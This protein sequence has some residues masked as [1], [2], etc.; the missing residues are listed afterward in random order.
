MGISKKT[1]YLYVESKSDLIDKLLESTPEEHHNVCITD[2]TGE[3]NAID[4]LLSVSKKVCEEISQFNPSITFDLQKYY[5]EIF[6]KFI[7]RK[8]QEIYEKIKCNIEKGIEEDIYRKDLDVDLVARLYVQRLEIFNN[9]DFFLSV[10]KS[11]QKVFGVMFENHIRGIS[12][13][14]G[15]AYLEKQKQL[16]NDNI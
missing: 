3:G 16:L 4:I 15:I 11:I 14:N 9:P 5:P 6:K 12:N 10:E 13:A 7:A 2:L 1:M 8:R